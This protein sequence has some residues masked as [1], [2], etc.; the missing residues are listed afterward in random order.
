MI[1]PLRK[2][3]VLPMALGLLLFPPFLVG[4]FVLDK[5][6]QERPVIRAIED[7]T[8]LAADIRSNTR[9]VTAQ[10]YGSDQRRRL[11][12]ASAGRTYIVQITKRRSNREAWRRTW[13]VDAIGLASC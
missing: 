11:C 6:S 1:D 4:V 9:F 3:G 7:L 13:H 12:A 2:A 5:R 10:G 8:G